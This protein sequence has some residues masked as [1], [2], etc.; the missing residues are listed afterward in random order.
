MATHISEA[1][2]N[3]A[4]I[5]Q[6]GATLGQGIGQ[7]MATDAA[8]KKRANPIV[9]KELNEAAGNYG[10]EGDAEWEAKKAAGYQGQGPSLGKA[11]DPIAKS[12]HP[13]SRKIMERY[14]AALEAGTVTAEEVFEE[15]KRELALHARQTAPVSGS[16]SGDVPIAQ[17]ATGDVPE[18]VVQVPGAPPGQA[19]MGPEGGG[20][21]PG[22]FPSQ[23]AGTGPSLGIPMQQANGVASQVEG[24]AARAPQL[25]RP[26][27]VAGLS[28]APTGS[29]S[30]SGPTP[31]ADE[32]P[33]LTRS[34]SKGAFVPIREQ[35]LEQFGKA[36]G[37]IATKQKPELETI[38]AEAKMKSSRIVADAKKDLEVFKQANQ[39][40]RTV[41]KLDVALAVAQGRLDSDGQQRVA[42]MTEQ[43]LN[44]ET[45]LQTVRELIAQK[46]QHDKGDWKVKMEVALMQLQ[47]GLG[48][49]T[50]MLANSNNLIIDPK[51]QSLLEDADSSQR[52]A[53]KSMMEVAQEIGTER[54]SPAIENVGKPGE[55]P[56]AVA[57]A[58]PVKV[59][60]VN[61]EPAK[62]P[63]PGKK[64]KK[65][66]KKFAFNASTGQ[67]EEVK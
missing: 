49:N 10:A 53:A 60:D 6:G 52:I 1:A 7:Q 4:L 63:K 37:F 51:V 13:V 59:P 46:D 47:T 50:A 58:A 33:S 64:D 36:G 9:E 61:A 2:D 3:G 28:G 34:K 38:K 66:K 26:T 25:G 18:K 45:K 32:G 31:M 62:P 8:A 35:E 54:N 14:A 56:K 44:M 39:N 67:M 41:A 11:P 5:R 48:R 57:P 27:S 65:V 55:V 19:N 12:V 23:R 29:S 24:G 15:T 42:H 43:L 21:S 22:S 20:G 16:V 40:N 17:P 30:Q